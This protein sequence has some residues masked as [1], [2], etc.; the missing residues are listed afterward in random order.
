MARQP[1]ANQTD[2]VTAFFLWQH[3]DLYLFHTLIDL[4]VA[5]AVLL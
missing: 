2:Y 3:Y 4:T 5:L 1:V